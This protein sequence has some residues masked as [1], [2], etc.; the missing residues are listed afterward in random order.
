MDIKSSILS[1]APAPL[2][3]EMTRPFAPAAQATIVAAVSGGGDSV[4][5]L[6]LLAGLAPGRG[7]TL[8]VATLDHGLRGAAGEADRRF[9][10]DLARSLGLPCESGRRDA[11]PGLGRSP[12][13][14]ARDVR[15][16]FLQ[17]VAARVRAAAVALGHTQDDQAETVLHRLGRGAGLSGLGAMR[18]FSPPF[19][20]PL[21]GVRRSV[22][23][24]LL[25]EA[26]VAWREDETNQLGSSA[27]SRIRHELMPAVERVLGPGATPALARFAALAA[28][29]EEFLAQIAREKSASAILRTQ[30]DVIELDGAVLSELPPALSRR[31]L[32]MCCAALAGDRGRLGASHILALEALARRESPGVHADLPGGIA[33]QRKGRILVLERV[34]PQQGS[35]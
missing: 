25:E 12:E 16:A 8:V 14:A 2:L 3:R 4:A 5:L 17:D 33:A 15:R 1:L 24:R 7:W 21:L 11:R 23:R 18:R 20:R 29:D 31:I 22:L 28:E 27:R 26:G 35:R 9:V 32:R 6:Q 19:W 13:E 30:P 34:G 10:E